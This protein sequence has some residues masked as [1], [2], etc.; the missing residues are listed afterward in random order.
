MDANGK[1]MKSWEYARLN[2]VDHGVYLTCTDRQFI[3][4]A[5][6][7]LKRLFPGCTVDEQKDLGDEAPSLHLAR[8]G[9]CDHL[10][11]QWLMRQLSHRGWELFQ[12]DERPHG[13]GSQSPLIAYFQS[14][15]YHFRRESG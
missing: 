6:P 13:T 1:K 4:W 5:I 15:Y 11:G 14:G 7:E 10:T 2:W 3:D 12:V 8:L 9:G